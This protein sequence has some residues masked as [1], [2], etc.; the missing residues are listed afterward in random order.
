MTPE[1][2]PMSPALEQAVAEIRDEA[3]DSGGGGSR[4]RPRVGALVEAA[5]RA[6]L[7]PRQP[8]YP[9]GRSATAPI[10]KL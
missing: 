1:F 9:R 7:K 2:N 10:F 6:C 5:R 4:R 3:V 8:P